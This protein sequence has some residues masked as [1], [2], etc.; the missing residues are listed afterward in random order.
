M[1]RSFALLSVLA[2]SACTRHLY[3]APVP[4]SAPPV[5][6][7]NVSS[8]APVAGPSARAP[9]IVDYLRAR[10]Q[11]LRLASYDK[12]L[13]AAANAIGFALEAGL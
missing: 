4:A 12:R 3:S 6:L 9:E 13:I 1:R 10:G 2:L 7:T 5:V 11:T 8:P